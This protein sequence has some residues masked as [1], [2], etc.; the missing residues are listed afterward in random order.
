[1]DGKDKYWGIA[2]DSRGTHT[3]YS[4]P[5]TLDTLIYYHKPYAEFIKPNMNVA[6]LLLQYVTKKINE[7]VKK[8]YT[9]ENAT[10]SYDVP[11]NTLI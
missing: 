4:H 3:F 8:G 2:F 7:K 11:T 1:M 5:E 10:A 9:L 6:E